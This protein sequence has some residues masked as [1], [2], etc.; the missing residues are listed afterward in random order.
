MPIIPAPVDMTLSRT[1]MGTALMYTNPQTGR[2]AG[3]QTDRQTDR[4]IYPIILLGIEKS[5]GRADWF[6]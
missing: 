4:H 5:V 3:R 1:S 2:Q 6:S